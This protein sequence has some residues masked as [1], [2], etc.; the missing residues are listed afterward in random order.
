M[1]RD[2]DEFARDVTGAG[3]AHVA[4]E[5][6]RSASA[7]QAREL[8]RRLRDAQADAQK[9]TALTQQRAAR[10]GKSD[11]CRDRARGSHGFAWNGSARKRVAP[12]STIFPRP[13]AAR[14]TV[15]GSK[16][17]PG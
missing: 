17:E 6:G 4:P 11:G 12:I 16:L 1:D 2:A 5:S 13:S 9:C 15:P 3:D 14:R 10:S 8:A 7:E